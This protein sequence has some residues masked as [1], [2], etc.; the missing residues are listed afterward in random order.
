MFDTG[1]IMPM[2]AGL[3]EPVLICCP[4]VIFLPGTVAQKLMKLFVDVSEAT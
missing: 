4:F 3:Q 2:G 1:A